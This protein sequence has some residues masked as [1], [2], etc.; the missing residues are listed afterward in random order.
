MIEVV[1]SS[2]GFVEPYH[3]GQAWAGGTFIGMLGGRISIFLK[4]VVKTMSVCTIKVLN[5]FHPSRVH[6]R[7]IR[8]IEVM[9]EDSSLE[10]F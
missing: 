10:L 8:G 4:Y 3:L 6:L 5:G 9:V 7:S 2:F 1:G